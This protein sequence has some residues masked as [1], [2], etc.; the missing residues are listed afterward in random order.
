MSVTTKQTMNNTYQHNLLSI[1]YNGWTNYETWNVALW[2]QND[3]GFYDLARGYR[4]DG[5]KAFAEMMME[6]RSSTPD[7][8]RWDDENLNICELNEMMEEL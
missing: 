6:L 2:L 1:E 3:P 7:D 5:Y 4:Y 8:V